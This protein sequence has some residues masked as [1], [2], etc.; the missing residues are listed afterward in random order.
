MPR[1]EYIFSN[2]ISVKY[3]STIYLNVGYHHLPIDEGSIT[4]TAIL[5]SEGSF[6]IGTTTSILQRTVNK[7]LKDFP[8]AIAYLDDIIIYSK[9]CR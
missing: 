2:L 9:N 7:E 6:W 4:K 3:F 1:V 8:F 5:I